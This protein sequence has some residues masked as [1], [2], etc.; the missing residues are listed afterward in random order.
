VSISTRTEPVIDRP[1]TD[2]AA[3]KRRLKQ[4]NAWRDDAEKYLSEDVVR[5]EELQRFAAGDQWPSGKKSPNEDQSRARLVVN[6]V[7][8]VL[9]TFAGRQVL[10]RFQRVYTAKGPSSMRWAEVM[11]EVDETFADACDADGVESS[12]FRD[13]AGVQGV[14]W[15]RWIIDPQDSAFT[16]EDGTALPQI[17]V[18]EIPLWSMMWDPFSRESNLMDRGWHAFGEYWPKAKIRSRGWTPSSDS[19]AYYGSADST[20]TVKSSRIPWSGGERYGTTDAHQ[21]GLADDDMFVEY[22]EWKEV[23]PDLHLLRPNDGT[24]SW[25]DSMSKQ[26][27][28]PTRVEPGELRSYRQLYQ[29]QWGVPLPDQAVMEGTRVVYLY[30]YKV[31]DQIFE[32][33][34]LLGD[35]QE[36]LGCFTFQAITGEA[37]KQRALVRWRGLVHK[38]V[39][40]QRW[41]NVFISMLVRDLQLS[42]KGGLLV[43]RGVFENA[44]A[45]RAN[46]ATN[47]PFITVR[48]GVISAN[49]IVPIPKANHG[50]PQLIQPLLEI[51]KSA[52]PRI[53]GFNPASLGQV[54]DPRRVASKVVRALQ[55]SAM[56][57]NADLF[58]NLRRF[59]K[60]GGVIFLA[61]LKGFYSEQDVAD[62]LD[63]ETAY[64][65]EDEMKPN[66]QTGQPEATGQVARKLDPQTQQPILRVP[67][68]RTWRP[69]FWRSIS[70]EEVA[71]SGDALQDLWQSLMEAGGGPAFFS[72]QWQDIGAPLFTAGD[73]VD[74][75]PYLP[76]KV[77]EKMRRRV[78]E[79]KAQRDQAPPAE[80]PPTVSIAYKDLEPAVK[81][82]ILQQR[83]VQ[84]TMADLMG[85][86]PQQD[87]AAQPQQQPPGPLAG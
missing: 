29:Q 52:I 41:N 77:R 48:P 54:D 35:D 57:A 49:R 7:S 30:A 33:G 12:V 59:R 62:I 67:P 13:G 24:L 11:T 1:E 72:Q 26:A 36:T 38:L 14:A 86:P 61:L 58:D 51:M 84:V 19:A 70:V 39:D 37:F 17:R 50:V 71:P 87:P 10:D 63:E 22:F 60:Q 28:T 21:E 45:A 76:T 44:E 83:G 2:A 55:D 74:L 56:A 47:S 34:E 32:Q 4:F 16:R 42:P 40:P 65:M 3:K 79:L 66:P 20:A 27:V 82:K 81:L 69:T 31:G 64:E 6:E 43:E 25:E 85:L 15:Q 78:I 23:Q 68:K 46:W 18:K 73:M 9:G 53:A 8:S 75:I 5:A 80:P